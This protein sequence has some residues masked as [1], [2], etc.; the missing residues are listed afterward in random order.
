MDKT[1][2]HYGVKGMKWG[3]R[4]DRRS[5]SGI[6]GQGVSGKSVKKVKK[7]VNATSDFNRELKNANKIRMSR[8]K[9]KRTRSDLSSMSDKELRE[10]INREFLERQY[11]DLFNQQNVSKGGEYVDTLLETTGSV[12]AVTATALGIALAIKELKG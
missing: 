1:L 6:S 12:L 4:K 8:S 11:D 2:T 3:V 10:R 9:K 7:V 5:S